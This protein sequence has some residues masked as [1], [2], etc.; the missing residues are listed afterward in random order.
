MFHFLVPAAVAAD[1]HRL[2]QQL[3]FQPDQQHT[4]HA[5][6]QLNNSSDSSN[7][8]NINLTPA[9][10]EM[11]ANAANAQFLVDE[12]GTAFIQQQHVQGTMNQYLQQQQQLDAEQQ[13]HMNMFADGGMPSSMSNVDCS[14][15]GGG[16]VVAGMFHTLEGFHASA[17]A[18]AAAAGSDEGDASFAS[19]QITYEWDGGDEMNVID[20]LQGDWPVTLQVNVAKHTTAWNVSD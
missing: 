4:E 19:E 17:A 16:S 2:K 10:L 11:S 13:M 12:D 15:G 7:D 9:Q 14:Q 3:Q 5:I 6:K 20:V 1:Y 8:N 18:A